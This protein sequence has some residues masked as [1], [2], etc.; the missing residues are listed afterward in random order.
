MAALPR[1]VFKRRRDVAV[2]PKTMIGEYL[3]TVRSVHQQ[4]ENILHTNPEIADNWLSATFSWIDPYPANFAHRLPIA[5]SRQIFQPEFH[6]TERP[7]QIR[8]FRITQIKQLLFRRQRQRG[9]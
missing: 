8:A 1:S 6:Q 9:V 3:F 7:G 5:A 4:I 2:F